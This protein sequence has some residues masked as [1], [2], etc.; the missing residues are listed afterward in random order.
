M[1]R[2]K[3]RIGK[4]TFFIVA[5]LILLGTYLTFFGLENYYGD[6][7]NVYVKGADDIRWGIDIRG[8]VEAIFSPDK[9]DADIT[10]ED[11]D[12]AKEIIETRLV[13][14][15]ITD[16]EVYTDY[17]SHQIMVRFPWQSDEE[18]YDPS[19][20]VA[21]LGE[22]ALLTF[23]EGEDKTGAVI[24][25]GAAD[26]DGASVGYNEEQGYVVQ[27]SLTSQGK[28]K[29]AEATGRLINKVISIWMDE[30]MISN[31]TVNEAITDGNA[32][33][34]FGTAATAGSEEVLEEA[35]DLAQKIN[36]GSLP[37]ALSVDDSALQ[38]VS[39]TLGQNALNIMVI[40]G[41]IAVA[42]VCLIMIFLYRLPGFVA[43]IALIGQVAGM[44]A[45]VSGF[46]PNIPSFTLTIPGIAGII[47]SIG[48]GV[49]ANVITSERIKEEFENGKTIDGAIS[50]GFSSAWTSIFDGNITNV[51]VS[52]V[53][54]AA[55]GTPDSF[56][57]RI[58]NFLTPFLSSAV[59]GAIYSFGYTTL[60][61]IV[62]N[63]V[64]GVGASRLML[65]S[66]SK[67][68]FLRKPWLYGGAK[69]A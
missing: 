13:N 65:M 11:M 44:V 61:G 63:F 9:A 17:Q 68:K 42:V 39:P 23:R 28:A 53:L 57:T 30:T 55:F 35:K 16:S 45:A 37:F 32:I 67:F 1:K 43:S 54:L 69:N 62:F 36:A 20:A 29:F 15:N 12:A 7:R 41:A 66:I 24:L 4:P 49:D 60:M 33:I 34:T 21:E 50:A 56:L 18:D 19:A 52:V 22:T 27:L 48:F 10:N 51:I 40:A 64:M 6:T 38:V 5:I 25:Q 14:Q 58:F 26:I 47:L 31:P 59:T 46:F 8:G 3:R 2:N